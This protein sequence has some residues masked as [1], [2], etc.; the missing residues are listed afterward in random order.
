M[1]WKITIHDLSAA[2]LHKIKRLVSDI[3]PAILKIPEPDD[4]ETERD[5]FE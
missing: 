3:D 1:R 2:E 4:F 5:E